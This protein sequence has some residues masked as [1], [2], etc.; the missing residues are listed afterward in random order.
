MGFNP[1][2]QLSPQLLL[3]V[4]SSQWDG[5]RIGKGKV[6]KLLAEIKVKQKPH[7]SKAQQGILSPL[8]MAGRC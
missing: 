1:G 2:R 5:E 7:V 8:P 4:H 6:R 3:L